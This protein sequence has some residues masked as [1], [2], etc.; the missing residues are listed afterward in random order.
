[1]SSKNCLVTLKNKKLNNFEKTSSM[2]CEFAGAGIYFDRIEYCAFDDPEEITRSISELVGNYAQIVISCPNATK[3]ALKTFAEKLFC[4]QFDSFDVLKTE[5]CSVYI[6]VSDGESRLNCRDIIEL[7]N[8]QNSEKR[9]KTYVKTVGAPHSAVTEAIRAAEKICG[10]LEF[11]VTEK[12]GDCTVEIVY[13]ESISKSVF[14]DAL[15]EVIGKLNDYIYALDESTLAQMLYRLLKLRRMKIS[16]AESFT[17]GGIAKRLVEVP[18]V[19]EVYFEGINA[20]ANKS[21]SV[22]LG[23][24]ELTLAQY[25]AVSEQTAYEMA[26]GLLKTGCCTVAISTTG[27]A[28]PASDDTLKPVGLNYIGVG[29]PNGIKVFKYELKGTREQ[30]TETAINFALFN[31]FK[32]LR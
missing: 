5:G 2:L 28:G 15:R 9:A 27:I 21:K 7:I 14:D 22:R 12:F 10:Q 1:M 24:S 13:H 19:S 16:V 4:G 29:T 8:S 31:T 30:I 17:G 3:T 6:T 18:G 25:G 26:E 23:V 11:N 32:L 20:Y